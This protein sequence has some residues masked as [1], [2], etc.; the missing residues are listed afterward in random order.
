MLWLGLPG[1]A[2][3]GALTA[4]LGAAGVGASACIYLVPSRPAWNSWHTPAEFALTAAVLGPLFAGAMGA[5]HQRILALAAAVMAGG[6][7]GLSTLRFLGCMASDSP[8]LRGTARLMSTVL[9]RLVL[10]RGLMLGLGAIVLPLAIPG[11][12]SMTGGLALTLGAQI[13]SRYLFFVSVV[14][15]H[16]AAPYLAAAREAA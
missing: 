11:V 14:P 7:F 2:W 9:S 1:S 16:L 12:V 15:K 13:L 10:W 3:A 5:G 6:L 8:E 4:I